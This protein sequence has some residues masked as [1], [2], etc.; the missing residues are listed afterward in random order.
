[1]LSLGKRTPVN[2][3]HLLCSQH[4]TVCDPITHTSS[5]GGLCPVTNWGCCDQYS[6]NTL[7]SQG[8]HGDDEEPHN[9]E[10]SS[11]IIPSLTGSLSRE[12]VPGPTHEDEDCAVNS[13]IVLGALNT[14]RARDTELF[15]VPGAL[16]FASA[17]GTEHLWCHGHI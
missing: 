14:N 1:M 3:R 7:H 17:S 2:V 10:G 11:T 12:V 13:V 8:E 9:E 16:N 15:Q 5:A 6:H 4:Q